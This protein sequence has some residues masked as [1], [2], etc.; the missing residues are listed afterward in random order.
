MQVL[1]N[2]LRILQCVVISQPVGVSDVA[3]KLD[4]PKSSVQRTLTSLEDEGWLTR[5]TAHGGLWVQTSRIWVLAHQGK[6]IGV[7]SL[8]QEP[9][10][11]LWERTNEN[12]HLTQMQGDDVV[13]VDKLESTHSVRVFDPIGTRLPLHVSAS[14]KAL[15][16]ARSPEGLDAYLQA[17]PAGFTAESL[18]EERALRAELQRVSLD[19]YA[20]NR[21][22]WRSEISGIGVALRLDGDREAEFGLAIS[23]PSHR[24]HEDQL[25]EYGELLLE[26][27]HRIE[28]AMPLGP[29]AAG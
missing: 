12:I 20:V 28:Q 25:A 19:G 15:L 14:G 8:A 11:W 1:K 3:R 13:V 21:G 5:D 18:T 23:V 24:L 29:G 27:K 4:L 10:H 2:A 6:E 7:R 16:A 9:M 22:E 17:S 26:A